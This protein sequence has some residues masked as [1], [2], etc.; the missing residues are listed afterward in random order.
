MELERT[1]N[2]Q[3]ALV[4]L[5]NKFKVEHQMIF[6]TSMI[7]PTLNNTVHCIGEFYNETNK[8]LKVFYFWRASK[9]GGKIFLMYIIKKLLGSIG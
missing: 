9:V 6:T 4:D 1:Q 3:K 2:F 8:T 7:N 5:S